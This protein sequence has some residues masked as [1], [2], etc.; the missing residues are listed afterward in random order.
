MWLT[1]KP[2]LAHCTAGVSLSMLPWLMRGIVPCE[3]PPTLTISPRPQCGITQALIS[4][5][6]RTY[7]YCRSQCETPAFT[8][9]PLNGGISRSLTGKNICH[10]RRRSRQHKC[11][12]PIG[13]TN[14]D[15]DNLRCRRTS[16]RHSAVH[17]ARPGKA[18]PFYGFRRAVREVGFACAETRNCPNPCEER[19]P[20]DAAKRTKGEWRVSARD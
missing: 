8:D 20:P 14:Y 11:A 19:R 13:K 5:F 10:P 7:I 18:N 3:C 2:A 9:C 1:L 15:R 16:R 6:A 4:R 17:C 12:R